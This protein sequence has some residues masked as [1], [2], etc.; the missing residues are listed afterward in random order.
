M[1]PQLFQPVLI[2]PFIAAFCGPSS[3]IS[4]VALV[5]IIRIL[6]PQSLHSTDKHG[7]KGNVV[8]LAWRSMYWMLGCGVECDQRGMLKLSDFCIFSQVSPQT[9]QLLWDSGTL[10]YPELSSS[11]LLQLKWRIN[12]SQV[13]QWLFQRVYKHEWG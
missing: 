9:T 5:S 7:Y 2:L 1:N 10:S 11:C 6:V 13:H 3:L 8:M 12:F 4:G